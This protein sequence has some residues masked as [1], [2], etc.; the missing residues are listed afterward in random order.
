MT[1]YLDL[2]REFKLYEVFRTPPKP[3]ADAAA[4]S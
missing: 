3:P 1:V 2:T 4:V